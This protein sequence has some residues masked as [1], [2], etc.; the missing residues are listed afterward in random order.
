MKN[1]TDPTLSEEQIKKYLRENTLSGRVEILHEE[2]AKLGTT[3]KKEFLETARSLR[4]FG[5]GVQYKIEKWRD[6]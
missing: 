5:H 4:R 1:L 2:L 6:R 3:L